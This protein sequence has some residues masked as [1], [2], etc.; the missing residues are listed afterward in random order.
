MFRGSYS[1]DQDPAKDRLR[2]PH[3][4]VS[5]MRGPEVSKVRSI[6]QLCG[7]RV[8]VE[9][10]VAPKGPLKCKRCQGFGLTQRNS[11]YAPG[12]SCVMS[13]TSPVDALPNGERL[14]AVTAHGELRWLCKAGT[15]AK[16]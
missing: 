2:T 10:Y 11:R 6:T 3:F 16:T 8:T 14:S 12:A 7:V 1:R 5:V 13:P 9:T 4:I 15:R